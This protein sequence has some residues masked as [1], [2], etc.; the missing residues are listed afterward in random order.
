MEW[1]AQLPIRVLMV[2]QW[3]KLRKVA[4]TERQRAEQAEAEVEQF[5]ATL[6]SLSIDPHSVL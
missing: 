2:N 1:L 3:W 4:K 5:K 6:Q